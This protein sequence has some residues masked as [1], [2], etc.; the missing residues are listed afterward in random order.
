MSSITLA[1]PAY[2]ENSLFLDVFSTWLEAW[3]NLSSL[4]PRH[5]G[6]QLHFYLSDLA[7]NIYQHSPD[8]VMRKLPLYINDWLS[9]Y[10]HPDN[11]LESIYKIDA[12]DLL[13]TY[14]GVRKGTKQVKKGVDFKL[15]GD[16]SDDLLQ[17]LANAHDSPA[18]K[19]KITRIIQDT[20]VRIV[21]PED[22]LG[23]TLRA[24]EK[25]PWKKGDQ[26]IGKITRHPKS[27]T[28]EKHPLVHRLKRGMTCWDTRVKVLL[29]NNVTILGETGTI[30]SEGLGAF[31]LSWIETLYIPEFGQ[32]IYRIVDLKSLSNEVS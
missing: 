5:Q 22:G 31:P 9:R 21:V 11:V 2:N 30:D 28:Q 3:E 12:L 32:R 6:D 24:N 1:C 20:F 29:Q 7:N 13:M 16:V 19:R 14:M 17:L 27:Q 25:N 8:L 10:V 26:W 18:E 4:M 15:A 23:Y